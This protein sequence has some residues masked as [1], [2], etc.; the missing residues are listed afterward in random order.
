MLMV[1]ALKA[2]LKKITLMEMEKKFF[3]IVLFIRVISEM[4]FSMDKVNMCR[5]TWVQNMKVPGFEMK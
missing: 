3:K 1:R 5:N 2:V 4:D